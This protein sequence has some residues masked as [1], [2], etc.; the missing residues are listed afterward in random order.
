MFT[1]LAIIL[2]RAPCALGCRWASG[3]SINTYSGLSPAF[4]L[5]ISKA[6]TLEITSL[7]PEGAIAMGK[8]LH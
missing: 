6:I 4:P 3:S 8:V 2:A 5:L 1:D 7:T